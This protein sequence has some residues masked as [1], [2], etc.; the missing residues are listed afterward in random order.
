MLGTPKSL[1]PYRI[2]YPALKNFEQ[3]I[4]KLGYFKCSRR[5]PNRKGHGR[6]TGKHHCGFVVNKQKTGNRTRCCEGFNLD[7]PAPKNF[8]AIHMKR[9]RCICGW[10]HRQWYVNSTS[11]SNWCPAGRKVLYTTG[12]RC[13]WSCCPCVWGDCSWAGWSSAPVCII[14][15]WSS[16]VAPGYSDSM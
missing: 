10:C 11:T 13:V 9:W 7:C 2:G 5:R 6:C 4:S 16:I 14:F 15:L 8:T 1:V 12:I 3:T